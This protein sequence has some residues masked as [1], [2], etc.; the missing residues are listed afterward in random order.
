MAMGVPM[1]LIWGVLTLFMNYVPNIGALLSGGPPI[2]L[3][4]VELGWT[5][6]LSIAAGLVVI[7]TVV[8]NLVD[9]FLQGNML[10][11]SVYVTLASLV[12]WGWLWGAA[13]AVMA[14]LLTV[15]I[16]TA[17]GR[18][19]AANPDAHS[20]RPSSPAEAQ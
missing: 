5:K 12:F 7:E 15:T 16:V 20:L 6:G 9:P 2:V 13:G 8:G 19:H 17:V 1:A 18:V 4:I 3:A 11:I 14:P 10:K